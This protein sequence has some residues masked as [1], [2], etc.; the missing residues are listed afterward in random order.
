[1][2]LTCDAR[3]IDTSVV[4]ITISDDGQGFENPGTLF[5]DTGDFRVDSG[6]GL[7]AIRKMI[8]R[9]RGRYQCLQ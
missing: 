5:L 2:R 9:A 6:Y 7:L 1:M 8:P 3:M 4:E